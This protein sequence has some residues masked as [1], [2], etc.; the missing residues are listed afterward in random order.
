MRGMGGMLSMFG[1]AAEEIESAYNEKRVAF[2]K[3]QQE[4]NLEKDKANRMKLRK[5]MESAKDNMDQAKEKMNALLKGVSDAAG[6]AAGHLSQ[7]AKMASQ[8]LKSSVNS[9]GSKLSTGLK[10]IASKL[11]S[12]VNTIKSKITN[13]KQEKDQKK[14]NEQQKL[15]SKYSF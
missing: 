3:A 4:Y 2:L 6:R 9:V 8:K 1:G 10:S 11:S 14:W 12:G 15:S 7:S 13:S 5:M